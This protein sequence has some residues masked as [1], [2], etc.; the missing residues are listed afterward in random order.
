[1]K[2]SERD[3]ELL[4]LDRLYAGCVRGKG[5]V[6]LASGPVGCGKTALLQVF[7]K[8]VA[9][10]GG[11]FSS[12]TASASERLHQFGLIDQLVRALRA[13]GMDADPFAAED[14]GVTVSAGDRR[15]TP[16]VP[17]RVLQRI[18][19]SICE[20]AE[21]R[22]LVLGIDDVHVADESSLQCLR[23]LIRRIDTSAVLI[24]LNES[25]CHEREMAT[26]HAETLHLPYCHL[27]RLAPLAGIGVA[28][29]LTRRLGAM[30]KDTVGS[31]AEVSGGNP[32]L[33]HALVEDFLIKKHPA[34]GGSARTTTPGRPEPGESF[35]HA[36]L[37]CVHRCEPS[38]LAAARALAVL[39][40]SASP[41]LI[42]DFV[43]GD[44]TSVRRSLADLNAAGLLADMR[45]RHERA[46]HA[47]LADISPE[48]LLTM[49]G[50]AAE[51]LH[52]SGASARVVADQLMATRDVM[53][54]PWRV[55]ILRDAAREA[56]ESG[57]IA[58][59]IGYLRHASGIC[60]DSA[61]EAHIFA[62]LA[63][64]QW[65]I[66]P[67]KATRHLPHLSHLVRVGLLTG[68]DAMVPVKH[69]LWR[70][71]IAQADS[72]L[73]TI[74]SGGGRTP[75]VPPWGTAPVNINFARLWLSLCRPESA[76]GPGAKDTY[77]ENH[78]PH[79]PLTGPHSTLALTLLNLSTSLS[80]DADAPQGADQVLHSTHAGSPLAP[81]LFALLCLIESC[82]HDEAILWSERLLKEPWIRRVPL[83]RALL[84]TVRSAAALRRGDFAAAAESARIALEL[85]APSAWGM[86]VGLPL[87]LAVRAATEL[88]DFEK[89]MRY[90]NIAV[91]PVM[92]GTPFALPYLQALGR[93]HLAMG[94]PHTALTHFQSCGEMLTKWQ[95]DTPELSDWR[96]DAAAALTAMGWVRQARA[97]IEQQLSLLSDE[98]CRARGI[99]LRRLAAISTGRDRLSLL[100]E[101]IQI[102]AACGDQVE[103]R[104]AQ[105]DME[106][107]LDTQDRPGP[108]HGRTVPPL[109]RKIPSPN[110]RDGAPSLGSASGEEHE[111]TGPSDPRASHHDEDV[112]GGA[113]EDGGRSPILSQLT[114]AELRVGALAT[115]GC[116]NREIADKLFITVSTV[117]Q[118]LTKIYR[119]LKV[120]SRSGL[121]TEL[122]AFTDIPCFPN[123]Q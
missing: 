22:S 6:V 106:A 40:E 52:K 10:K 9:E 57:D 32:L 72:L 48:D 62:A 101:A 54:A 112:R 67:A 2:V 81:T 80:G 68:D 45:F 55:Y 122:L 59:C 83:R 56:V 104:R 121:P 31:W 63:E 27:I 99:A 74:E 24:V 30:P 109:A 3:R 98:R 23:Y 17:L 115:A 42:G 119:K 85:V 28:D 95:L 113:A 78:H 92:F 38:M 47:V 50:R 16:P 58:E 108:P 51:L 61:Q 84:E 43:G 97:L 96:N 4:L 118:H 69:L 73:S 53:K 37:R 8:R 19:R 35:R 116:T 12:V 15:G 60:A 90:L 102:L 86:V 33:L 20:L 89:V 70:G 34:E 65:L 7:A 88:G 1:M 93:Y 100:N 36:F 11:L 120:R 71:D 29:Q 114:D 107:A 18:S 77:V 25:S 94:R 111:R 82:R 41:S 76:G 5:A 66:D 79:T 75:A 44:A 39:G 117:E 123:G 13:A 103:C 64:A 87:A 110:R 26:L 21:E 91:P 105:I 49:H 14:V 46:R